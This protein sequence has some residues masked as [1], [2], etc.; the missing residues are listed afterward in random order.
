[1]NDE[2]NP[3]GQDNGLYWGP[4]PDFECFDGLDCFD[5]A[6]DP[7]NDGEDE[8]NRYIRPRVKP[9]KKSRVIY[10]HA[11]EL[12]EAI[13]IAG[14]VRYDAI[15]SGNFIFGDFIEAFMVRNNC[16]AV[17]MDITTLS[18]GQE[19][20]D[21]LRTLIEK[22]YVDNLNLIV[23]IYF[24][25]HE[26]HRLIPYLYDRLD[27]DSRFQ[28]AIA[29]THMKTCLIE[30]LGGKKIII[31]GSANLRS[32]GNIEQ[33]TIEENPE[34]YEFYRETDDNILKAYATINK[35]IRGEQLFDAIRGDV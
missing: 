16:K 35:E 17:R 23:S 20:V 11:V 25:A 14:G 19:N 31:H 27:I 28:L 8:N 1:M 29:G 18:L 22:E 21:S 4:D 26:I 34:L 3:L 24:Y 33:F 10:K 7:W 6:G 30:T 32:S 12:A 13:D 15:V 5:T 9:F 2:R